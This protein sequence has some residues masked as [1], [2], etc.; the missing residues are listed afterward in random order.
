MGWCGWREEW[1]MFE[2]V[3]RRGRGRED[4]PSPTLPSIKK[5]NNRIKNSPATRFSP[6]LSGGSIKS[7]RPAAA[8]C[9]GAE[10]K[11]EKEERPEEDASKEF[12]MRLAA[13]ADEKEEE[14]VDD[15]DASLSKVVVDEA[16]KL[17]RS[18]W[19][20]SWARRRSI[21]REGRE[22]G[23]EFWKEREREKESKSEERLA[24]S[25]LHRLCCSSDTPSP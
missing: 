22:R 12:A 14:K 20:V 23:A 5:N 3:R 11:V 18:A 25:S 2:E 17:E 6:S 8:C 21:R 9:A 24:R 4:R 13:A 10:K 16:R 19:P 7:A 15:A 1:E